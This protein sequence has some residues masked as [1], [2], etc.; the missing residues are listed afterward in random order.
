MLIS[1]PRM[2]YLHY[3]LRSSARAS[4]LVVRSLQLPLDGSC[5]VRIWAGTASRMGNPL[6]RSKPPGLTAW[7]GF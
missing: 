3:V 7:I 2:D 6:E 1:S 4:R 5:D